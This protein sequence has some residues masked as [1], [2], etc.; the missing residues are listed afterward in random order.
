MEDVEHLP[1]IDFKGRHADENSTEPGMQFNRVTD[2]E[3][4]KYYLILLLQIGFARDQFQ[5]LNDLTAFRGQ[6]FQQIR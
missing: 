3:T 4:Q 1:L 6:S 2:A 5:R